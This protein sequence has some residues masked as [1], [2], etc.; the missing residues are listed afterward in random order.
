MFGYIISKSE[1]YMEDKFHKFQKEDL[2]LAPITKLKEIAKCYR[3]EDINKY[4]N[5]YAE[6]RYSREI[7]IKK[8]LIYSIK[9]DMSV[10]NI[11]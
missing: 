5:K 3:I 4:K 2:N 6:Q 10:T 7:L 8:S 1:K 11:T 9:T